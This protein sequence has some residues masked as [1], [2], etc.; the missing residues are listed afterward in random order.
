MILRKIDDIEDYYLAADVLAR[1]RKGED[2][3][4]NAKEVRKDLGL[5]Y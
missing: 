2:A 1:V 5:E 4:F 3:A